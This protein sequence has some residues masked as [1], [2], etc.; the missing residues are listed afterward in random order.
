VSE[1]DSSLDTCESSE[2]LNQ[3]SCRESQVL[4]YSG[5]DARLPISRCLTMSRSLQKRS[6]EH[7]RLYSADRPVR[8]PEASSRRRDRRHPPVCVAP[9]RIQA[10]GRRPLAPH[11]CRT[12]RPPARRPSTWDADTHRG[13]GHLEARTHT[14]RNC[15]NGGFS[16]RGG[17]ACAQNARTGR[18]HSVARGPI[19]VIDPEA[20]DGWTESESKVLEYRRA[21]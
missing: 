10:D 15:G 9:A 3:A 14:R 19:Q 8:S 5:R 2:R 4:K 16:A 12:R 21:R 17:P 20:L 13:A 11:C 1:Y 6:R 18:A 7:N